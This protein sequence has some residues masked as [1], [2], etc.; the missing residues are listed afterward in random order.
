M[1]S[2]EVRGL[3]KQWKPV[4][5]VSTMYAALLI[6]ERLTEK[7]VATRIIFKDAGSIIHVP[8]LQNK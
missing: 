1:F 8:L 6:Y 4:R 5:R 7:G 3:V 2:V